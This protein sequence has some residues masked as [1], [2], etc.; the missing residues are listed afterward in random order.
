MTAIGKIL[1]PVGAI[2]VLLVVEIY[3]LDI[4]VCKS[5]FSKVELSLSGDLKKE[6]VAFAIKPKVCI[7]PIRC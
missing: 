5:Y 7:N 2:S 6:R 1:N 4:A 3:D